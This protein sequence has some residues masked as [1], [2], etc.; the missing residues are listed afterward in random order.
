MKPRMR[1]RKMVRRSSHWGEQGVPA[2]DRSGA[3]RDP[4]QLGHTHGCGEGHQG[5]DTGG[6]FIV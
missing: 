6:H 1:R 4:R 2:D 3:E 5:G